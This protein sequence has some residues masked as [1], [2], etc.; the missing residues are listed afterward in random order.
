MF[1]KLENGDCVVLYRL[2][3]ETS[4][5]F[6]L[7]PRSKYGFQIHC[8]CNFSSDFADVRAT[9]IPQDQLKLLLSLLVAKRGGPMRSTESGSSRRFCSDFVDDSPVEFKLT[10]II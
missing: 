1:E 8:Y 2:S 6:H 7:A 3:S 4:I 9:K 5:I 10:L